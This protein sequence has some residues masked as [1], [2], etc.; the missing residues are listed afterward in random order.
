MATG[1][2]RN[3]SSLIEI[4]DLEKPKPVCE[5]DSD[6]PLQVSI[7]DTVV[8][9]LLLDNKPG[10]PCKYNGK[11]PLSNGIEGATGGFLLG[12]KLFI[13][14][15]SLI[16]YSDQPLKECYTPGFSEATAV[17]TEARS[18]ASSVVLTMEPYLWVTGG[19]NGT[20]RLQ[21]TELVSQN[22][23]KPGPIL[24]EPM[25]HM[26]IVTTGTDQIMI[27]GGTTNSGHSKK[28]YKYDMSDQ[29]DT[30]YENGPTLRVQRSALACGL[31]LTEDK[32]D[33]TVVVAGGGDAEKSIETWT[34]QDDSRESFQLKGEL[35]YEWQA[36]ASAS[37]PT[38]NSL[39]L[40]GNRKSYG[41]KI[42]KVQCTSQ[43]CSSEIMAQK[44]EIARNAPVVA[45]VYIFNILL[46]LLK[47]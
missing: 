16:D 11:Y 7:D 10:Y 5:Y 40:V 24:P 22:T 26:C 34:V 3:E 18:F 42:I 36:G 12:N 15:G 44:L 13:C 1:Y 30:K 29:N 17:M 46:S 27:I 9:N 31:L 37:V 28:S 45:C 21:S 39:I 23:T 35:P 47:A 32:R 14:G 41:D 4:I 8:D 6:F 25:S 19:W 33:L 38:I 43:K 2:A 20:N